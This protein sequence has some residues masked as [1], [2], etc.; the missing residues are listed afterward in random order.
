MMAEPA[1]QEALKVGLW[2]NLLGDPAFQSALTD[3]AFQQ[4]LKKGK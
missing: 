1:F 3:S 2:T 4:S